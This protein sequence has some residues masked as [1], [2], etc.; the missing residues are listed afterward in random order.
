MGRATEEQSSSHAN[1]R[2]SYGPIVQSPGAEGRVRTEVK[3]RP[4]YDRCRPSAAQEDYYQMKVDSFTHQM[5]RFVSATHVATYRLFGGMGP[6]NRNTLIL[7]TRGRKSGRAID[8]PLLYYQEDGKA[9]WVASYGGSDT[10]PAWYL[11]LT[12]NPEVEAQIGSARRKYRA[13]SLRRRSARCGRSCWRSIR[14]T[15]TI[16]RRPRARFR[17]SSSGQS[18]RAPALAVR[19]DSASLLTMPTLSQRARSS[20]ECRGTLR[21]ESRPACKTTSTFR[22]LR[23]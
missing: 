11:N 17:W 9:Y 5:I 1:H 12:A 21:A 20:T 7:T 4:E 15:P 16:R 22:P 13:R 18:D 23:A 2:A 6:L 14:A 19:G 3:S 10:P 8:K